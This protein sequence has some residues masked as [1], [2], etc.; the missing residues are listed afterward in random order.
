[1]NRFPVVM[2][3]ALLAAGVVMGAAFPAGAA[4]T[5]VPVAASAVQWKIWGGEATFRWKRELLVDYGID[6]SAVIGGGTRDAFGRER[7]GIRG[8]S[9]LDFAVDQ[10]SFAGFVR[11][12]LGFSGGF[13]LV[14]PQGAIGLR[15]ARLVP[16]ADDPFLIDLVGS[17]GVAWFYIDRLMYEIE[18]GAKAPVLAI[19]AADLRI[20][21]ALADFLGDASLDGLA[22]ADVSLV[23][24]ISSSNGDPKIFEPRG[25]SRWP[26]VAVPG[27]PGATYQ[28]DVFMHHFSTQIM[29][30]G[31]DYFEPAGG[32]KIVLAPSSTLRN[33]RSNGTVVATVPCA[34][35]PCPS[36]PAMLPDPL[37]TSTALYAA[38]V[39]WHQ[40]FTSPQPPYGND[41]HPYLIWNLYRI[42]ADGRIDQVARSGVKHAWLT[43]NSQCDANPGSGH[44]L[45]R[46]C[47]DTY[48]QFNNDAIDDLGPR[49]E[50]IPAKA[51]WGRCGSVYDKDCNG[52]Q[53]SQAPCSNLGGN[54]PGCQNWAF[55]MAVPVSQIDSTLHPGATYWVESWYIVRD[56]IDIFNTMQTR[57]ISFGGS[58]TSWNRTDGAPNDEVAG[59]KLGPAIDR[60]LARGTDT[61]T[62]RSSDIVA[63]HG[64]ARLAVKATELDG[65]GWR[66]DYVVANFDYTVAETEGSEP[67]L[68]VL[69]NTGFTGF[70]V[71]AEDTAAADADEFSDGDRDAGNDWAFSQTGE[72][73]R[74]TPPG[75]DM[76]AGTVNPL[77][78]GTMYRFS[79]RSSAAPVAGVAT[80]KAPGGIA[81]D[82]E[83]LVPAGGGE[84]PLFADGFEEDIPAH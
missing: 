50:I 67:N 76:G 8:G 20:G 73:L 68:R 39:A 25:S 55:R 9:A 34:A 21:A 5:P 6:V 81:I 17:D 15:D 13:D 40:K 36:A 63:T 48:S 51:Q 44:I 23:S 74:W 52:A 60:W 26:G 46:G 22:V 38:D 75:G 28:A 32:H 43:T 66:Y 42:D 27:V 33:N 1:M 70:E 78:W 2:M 59:L 16:R 71:S 35:S 77:N 31:T 49:S 4:E 79:F 12:S 11:G 10:G 61:P 83:T 82:V 19:K 56:D 62:E 29:M 57:A 41:Q 30:Q 80:L 58:G 72:A 65:G 64:Q 84:P 45:G 14:T 7:V 47:V 3:P 37:G 24:A 18:G 54:T 69:S 53:D